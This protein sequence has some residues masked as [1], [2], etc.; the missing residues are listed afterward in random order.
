MKP[1]D[2]VKATIKYE[3]PPEIPILWWIDGL[4]LEMRSRKQREAVW[5]IVKDRVF[6]LQLLSVS[7]VF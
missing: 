3:K 2:V 7:C 6:C 5:D 1:K 4:R